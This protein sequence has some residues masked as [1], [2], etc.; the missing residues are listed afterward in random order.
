MKSTFASRSGSALVITLS[1]LV[2]LTLL[3]VGMTMLMR[4]EQKGA[5]MLDREMASRQLAQIGWMNVI[6][7]LRDTIPATLDNNRYYASMPGMV[8]GVDNSSAPSIV[9]IGLLY[10][11]GTKVSVVNSTSL[12]AGVSLSNWMT[13]TP[14][15]MFNINHHD[16]GM[17]APIIPLND[18]YTL[19]SV[20][21]L[22]SGP[23]IAA[24][25]VGWRY[26]T[27]PSADGTMVIGRFAYW[28]DDEA[29]R[30]NINSAWRRSV[31]SSTTVIDTSSIDVRS[32]GTLGAIEGIA[33]AGSIA[34]NIRN[35][36]NW[37]VSTFHTLDQLK[38]VNGVTEDIYERNKFY[39]TNYGTPNHGTLS[40]G[41]LSLGYGANGFVITMA[42]AGSFHYGGFT[43]GSPSLSVGGIVNHG[44]FSFIRQSGAPVGSTAFGVYYVGTE[45]EVDIFQRPRLNY[46]TLTVTA[47]GIGAT[48]NPELYVR[49]S[50]TQVYSGTNAFT[51]AGTWTKLFPG[52]TRDLLAKYPIKR[53]S[54]I[55]PYITS[56]TSA[57]DGLQLIA[58]LIAFTKDS[59]SPPIAG[60]ISTTAGD[61]NYGIPM[62]NSDFGYLGVAKTVYL[63]EVAFNAVGTLIGTGGFAPRST[64]TGTVW[65]S[66][67]IINPYNVA[68]GDGFQVEASIT[69][70]IACNST[71][72]SLTMPATIPLPA[73]GIPPNSYHVLVASVPYQ[74]GLSGGTTSWTTYAFRANVQ[75]IRLVETAGVPTS[76][77]DYLTGGTWAAAFGGGAGATFI[78]NLT[79]G[80]V[81]TYTPSRATGVS[82][83][84]PRVPSVWYGP[85]STPSA[86]STTCG[87]TTSSGMVN[88]VLT[89][90][91]TGADGV[92]G[93]D[94][95]FHSTFYVHGTVVPSL[96]YLGYVHTGTPW[97]TL[98]F[99]PRTSASSNPPD[100]SSVPDWA[101]LDI[102]K[103]GGDDKAITPSTGKINI[104]QLILHASSG[105]PPIRRAPFIALLSDIG[106]ILG[107]NNNQTGSLTDAMISGATNFTQTGTFGPAPL[108]GA[109]FEVASLTNNATTD[110][111]AEHIARLIAPLVTA[112]SRRFTVWSVGQTIIDVNRNGFYDI[113]IDIISGE[114]RLQ[115][116]IERDPITNVYRVLYQRPFSE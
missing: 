80:S 33:P 17:R 103:L 114:S 4:T 62:L 104:N 93:T 28:T 97:R 101:I 69:A 102:F 37:P 56:A 112:R 108:A 58:N 65:C 66:V 87:T 34:D 21:S 116:T 2:A 79:K 76:L 10:S 70:Y 44:T 113:G 63:N 51:P 110:A 5:A 91:N 29:T 41:T 16:I 31:P 30:I 81:D 27:A 86:Y 42:G 84:D 82:K 39:F 9:K 8:V 38:F 57:N 20:S 14:D 67:E 24:I 48:M 78:M 49:L 83:D 55:S 74:F 59:S 90:G 95:A 36:R 15:K 73:G 26:V 23:N 3:V 88:S 43:A 22:A 61:V 18:F 77:R 13:V 52:T 100:S 54:S 1:L 105:S 47:G 46:N 109:I 99:R 75:Q 40:Q 71:N 7:T 106:G 115:T 6:A 45:A 32:P 94:P 19:S 25:Q 92:E 89:W 60:S 11:N 35:Y 64:F 12:T 72:Y 85:V 98:R 107:I 53:S 68:L 50:S 96:G 111:G